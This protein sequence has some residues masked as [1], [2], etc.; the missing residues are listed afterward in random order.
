MEEMTGEKVDGVEKKLKFEKDMLIV[1]DSDEKSR[2]FYHWRN[3]WSYSFQLLAT[4]CIAKL[5]ERYI[6]ARIEPVK[7]KLGSN[8]MFFYILYVYYNCTDVIGFDK[9]DAEPYDAN[10][11][12]TILKLPFSDIKEAIRYAESEVD[13]TFVKTIIAANIVEQEMEEE[14][15]KKE[16]ERKQKAEETKQSQENEEGQE[17]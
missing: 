9:L 3:R 4:S 1:D 16:E 5:G 15:R 11:R 17:D 12:G 14:R 10:Q 2:L 13:L 6:I 8:S 7:Y